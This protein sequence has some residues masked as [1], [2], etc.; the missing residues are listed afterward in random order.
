MNILTLK[1]NPDY[2]AG[3]SYQALLSFHKPYLASLARY[4][5]RRISRPGGAR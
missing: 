1:K 2:N 4:A 3:L 5:N